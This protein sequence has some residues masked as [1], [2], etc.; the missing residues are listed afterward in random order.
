MSDNVLQNGAP[1]EAVELN[2][3]GD[4]R[5]ETETEHGSMTDEAQ[6]VLQV[7]AWNRSY[8]MFKKTFLARKLDRGQITGKCIS[9][10]KINLLTC[11]CSAI[12]FSGTVGIGLF[13]TSGELIA[14]SGSLGCVLAFIFAGLII[15]GVMRSLAEMVSVRPLSG[16]LMDYPHTYVDEA[17]GFAVGIT[18][19]LDINVHG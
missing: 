1:G 19:W 10:S 3:L 15:T 17:L 8:W 18:Y 11:F 13:V 2:N 9:S 4:Q 16:A 14:I 7:N 6:N 5:S 12:G